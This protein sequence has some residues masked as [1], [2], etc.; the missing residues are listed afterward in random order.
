MD[1]SVPPFRPAAHATLTRQERFDYDLKACGEVHPALCKWMFHRVEARPELACALVFAMIIVV[2]H[3]ERPMVDPGNAYGLYLEGFLAQRG[4]RSVEPLERDDFDE[5]FTSL[6]ADHYI[7]RALGN[8]PLIV[9]HGAVGRI[10]REL[11]S[12]GF[13]EPDVT[14]HMTKLGIV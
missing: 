13:R 14:M 2:W 5:A 8:E 9:E 4:G 6:A 10:R 11:W 1:Q 12:A 3:L 7:A